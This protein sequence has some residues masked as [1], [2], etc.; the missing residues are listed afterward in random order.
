MADLNFGD[1]NKNGQHV[2]RPYRAK[3]SLRAQTSTIL[4]SDCKRGF[5]KNDIFSVSYEHCHKSTEQWRQA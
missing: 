1:D 2:L 3:A 5:V 4:F